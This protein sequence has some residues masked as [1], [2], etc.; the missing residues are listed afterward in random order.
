MPRFP[1]PRNRLLHLA[2]L[3]LLLAAPALQART[4]VPDL[5]VEG[6][7]GDIARLAKQRAQEKFSTADTDHDG[8]LSKQEVAARFPYLADTFEQHDKD[9]DGFLSWEEFIGHD[10]WPK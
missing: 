10:R 3:A 6:R 9:G 1:Y 2:T 5:D 7:R 8:K 4:M